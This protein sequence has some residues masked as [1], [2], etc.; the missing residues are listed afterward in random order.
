M[1]EGLGAMSYPER[2]KVLDLYSVK[3]RLLRADMLFIWRMFKGECALSPNVLFQLAGSITRGHS[4]KLFIT[5]C[6]LDIRRRSLAIRA[7]RT[8]NLLSANTVEAP[9]LNLF[10]KNLHLDL[11]QKLYDFDE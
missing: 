7:I 10:K 1:V 6:N 4:K 9:S 8:W 2:L 3:G 11:G 5:R